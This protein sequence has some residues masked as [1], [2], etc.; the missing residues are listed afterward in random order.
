MLRATRF[1]GDARALA[2]A[3]AA[4]W[5]DFS[6]ATSDT[7]R[8]VHG[9]FGKTGRRRLITFLDTPDHRLNSSGYVLRERRGVPGGEREVTLKF[10]HEDRHVTQS[11]DMKARRAKG[12]RTKF[13]EDIKT[14]FVSLYSYSTTVPV[15]KKW[16]AETLGDVR[17][18]FPDVRARVDDYPDD[19][20]LR[21][22]KNFIAREI[23]FDGASVRMGR[24]PKV[25]A[26]CALIVWYDNARPGNAPVAVEFSYRYGDKREE[27]GGAVARRAHDIFRRIPKA[28][29]DWVDPR[30]RTKTRFVYG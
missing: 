11:R 13:E 17:R 19:A 3:A 18:L 29:K 22:V 21:P 25:D 4:F 14:P 28:L 26:T 6:R 23:V 7:V 30:S 1:A 2:R 8:G 24:K 12:G 27:Y 20:E 10:R 5:Q 15:G 16:A 9:T